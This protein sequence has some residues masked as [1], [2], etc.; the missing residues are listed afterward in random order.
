MAIRASLK[1]LL[2]YN[3]LK[4]SVAE[5]S[6]VFM[7]VVYVVYYQYHA[8]DRSTTVA[9][10]LTPHP[11]PHLTSVAPHHLPHADIVRDY[12]IAQ[13][14]E[15]EL[16]TKQAEVTRALLDTWPEGG[17]ATAEHSTPSTCLRGTLRGSY[18]GTCGRRW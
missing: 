9:N 14:S 11:T 3:L 18:R 4:G 16:R 1:T 17:F 8:T 6:G 10:A 5:G 7:H 12:T 15:E 2:N 13:L